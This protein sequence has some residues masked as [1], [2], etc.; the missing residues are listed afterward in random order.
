MADD[1]SFEPR[2]GRIRSTGG[3]KSKRYV[4]RVLAATVLAGGGGRR[5]GARFDGSR[6]GRGA[7]RARV[8]ASGAHA[9]RAVVKA[10]LVR[11]GTKGVAAARAHL[12]YIQRDGVT[13]EGTPGKLYD[14]AGDEAD[15]KVF[16]DR[17]VD[18]R[19]QFRFIV[20][21]E[22]GA[23]YQ[24]LKP[25]VRRLMTQIEDDLGTK[26]DW[27]AV[28]HCNTGHPHTHIM[29]RGVD[30][31][32]QNLII[33]KDYIRHGMR[34]RAEQLVTLDLGPRTA[35]EI[36]AGLR[37]EIT[38]ERLTSIDRSLVRDADGE[39]IVTATGRDP[40][41]QALRA[42]RLQKLADLGLAEEM[43]AGRWRLGAASKAIYD[44]S[45]NAATSSALCSANCRLGSPVV[46]ASSMASMT[47]RRRPRPSSGGS[48][49]GGSPTSIKTAIS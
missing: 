44:R 31:Q 23:E 16:L 2:L 29:L 14:A 32:G 34:A 46:A 26:L 27:V 6:I 39:G 20:S 33:A 30:D 18:D 10:R 36:E 38:A 11:L 28:D 42:G 9:R 24:D 1:D 49:G 25:F 41:D 3:S 21:A 43:G 45:A 13:R 35:R 47:R 8:A 37:T 22:D 5:R 7:S 15:G 48:C 12:R 40:R 17:Q 19:H 4:G